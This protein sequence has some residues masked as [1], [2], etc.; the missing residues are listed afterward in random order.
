MARNVTMTVKVKVSVNFSDFCRNH[1]LTIYRTCVGPRRFLCW[2]WWR[3]KIGF[4]PQNSRGTCT[5]DPHGS[6]VLGRSLPMPLTRWWLKT[7]AC[8]RGIQLNHDGT[9]PCVEFYV[10][11]WTWP[12]ELTHR[13]I[14]G[15]ARILQNHE[16]S[17]QRAAKGTYE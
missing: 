14:F 7:R 4:I 17:G 2:D 3:L 13:V 9:P 15:R 12:L 11:W 10:P 16:I 6:A 5:S 1:M 8:S